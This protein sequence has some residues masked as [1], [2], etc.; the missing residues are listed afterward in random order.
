LFQES[1]KN[2]KR[3]VKKMRVTKLI[4]EYIEERVSERYPLPVKKE[5]GVEAAYSLMRDRLN[6]VIKTEA[7]IF[8]KE[9]IDEIDYVGWRSSRRDE[10][11][12]QKI[13]DFVSAMHLDYDSITPKSKSEY[14]KA[15]EET[16]KKRSKAVRDIIVELEMG[17]TKADLDALLANLPD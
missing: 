16:K 17:A 13:K 3:E 10:V 12:E 5:S 11:D 15:V 2:K 14:E 6:E 1:S 4:R 8:I 7:E 9:W